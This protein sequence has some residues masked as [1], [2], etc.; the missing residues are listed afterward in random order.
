M[1]EPIYAYAYP[2]PIVHEGAKQQV[3]NLWQEAIVRTHRAV[4]A[5]TT[6][7]GHHAWK[8]QI[9][10]PPGSSRVGREQCRRVDLEMGG[11]GHWLPVAVDFM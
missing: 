8:C 6:C 3:A 11:M 1:T 10:V 2:K 5:P 4:E 9:S 7:L